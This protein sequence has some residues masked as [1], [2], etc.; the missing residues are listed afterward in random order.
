MRRFDPAYVELRAAVLDGVDRRRARRALPAP[1]RRRPTRRRRRRGC[2]SNSMIH[3][4]D[5]VP[6]LL[7][8][9]LA[10][11]TVFAPRVPEGALQDVQVAVLETVGRHR[12]HR[13]GLRSTPATATTST[14]RSPAPRARSRSPRRTALGRAAAQR[15]RPR[16][17]RRTS[18]ARFA[19]AYRIELASWIAGRAR[20]RRRRP[21]R[22]GTAT[23]PTSPRSRPST[24]CTAAAGSRCRRRSARRSTAEVAGFW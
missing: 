4:F 12:G 13:R 14:P 24:R 9:P 6:W 3:E 8:D 18:S 7:D 1:Q 22:P 10:A 20:R 16:G 19:D 17:E 15:R 2:S 11:V 5:S 23:S 21:R